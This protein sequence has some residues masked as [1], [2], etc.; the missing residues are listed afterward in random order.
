MNNE[1]LSFIVSLMLLYGYQKYSGQSNS[2]TLNQKLQH[3]SLNF[4]QGIDFQF[5]KKVSLIPS[6]SLQFKS[7]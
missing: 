1:N 2:L 5:N 6:L 3:F 7:I 4:G